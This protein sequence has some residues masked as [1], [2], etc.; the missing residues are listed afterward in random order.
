MTKYADQIRH[1]RDYIQLP[2]LYDHWYVAGLTEEFDRKPKA[3]TLLERS[4]VFYRTEAGELVALQNRCLHRSFP[5]AEGF[6]E[7][8]ELVCGYHGVRYDASGQV[9]RVPCQSRFQNRSLKKYE[10][11]ENGPFVFIWMGDGEP[12][13]S[14]YPDLPFL[15]DTDNYRT[16]LDATDMQGSYLFMQENLNDLTHF[17]YLH[18][19][20]F[21]VDDRF[22]TLE[23]TLTETDLGPHLNRIDDDV[24]RIMRTL[25]P[26]AQPLAEGKKLERHDGGRSL[27]PGV[28]Q[29]YAPTLIDPDSD[30]PIVLEQHIMHYVTPETKSSC[31]YF[32]SITL[33]YELD[34]DMLFELQREFI[35]NGFEEDRWAVGHM[36]KVLDED[37]TEGDEMV[38]QSDQAGMLFRRRLLEWVIEEHGEEAP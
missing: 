37:T 23:S 13:E 30:D 9:L 15:S 31:H 10:V 5:L 18:R 24:E 36:Q 8:D 16:F 20:S 32:W 34:N 17:A 1:V 12:D 3:K 21:N 28:F 22:F 25:P 19:N 2:L 11:R 29:G 26:P 27:S 7:G 35:K 6:L 38:I 14:R 4:I 33:N